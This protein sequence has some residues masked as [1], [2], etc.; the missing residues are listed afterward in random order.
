MARGTDKDGPNAHELTCTHTHTDIHWKKYVLFSDEAI[1]I[2][3]K[4]HLW[5]N[6]C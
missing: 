3:Q 4:K 2:K 1:A 5:F 6:H